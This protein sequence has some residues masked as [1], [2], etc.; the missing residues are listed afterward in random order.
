MNHEGEPYDIIIDV[1]SDGQ[2]G[3]KENVAS[4]SLPTLNQLSVR[5]PI[6]TSSES[7]VPKPMTFRVMMKKG[8]PAKVLRDDILPKLLDFLTQPARHSLGT[9]LVVSDSPA[10]VSVA[11]ALFV[12]CLWYP[13]TGKCVNPISPTHH[14]HY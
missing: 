8:K 10:D 6:Y 11:V 3:E 1:S 5:T 14:Q 4:R 2:D 9:I 7:D 12:L 13:S